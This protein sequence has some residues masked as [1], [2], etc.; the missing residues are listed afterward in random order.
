MGYGLLSLAVEIIGR[1]F[2]PGS[3]GFPR[4][5]WDAQPIATLEYAIPAAVFGA[6]ETA[7]FFGRPALDFQTS[8]DRN[9]SN[10]PLRNYHQW[11]ASAVIKTGWRF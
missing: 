5:D 7:D 10:L 9:W 1:W 2:D 8:F 11:T 3:A 6:P 4:R